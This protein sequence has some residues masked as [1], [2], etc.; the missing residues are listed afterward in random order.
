MNPREKHTLE[1]L[2]KRNGLILKASSK[3][4]NIVV[5]DQQYSTNMVHKLLDD[6][7]TYEILSRNP[8]DQI[9]RCNGGHIKQLNFGRLIQIHFQ[10]I[11]GFGNLPCNTKSAQT[12][13]VRLQ[14]SLAGS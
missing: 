12:N 1:Y 13:R 11:S 10:Y 3:G 7:E 8:T 6:R 9:K 5:M 14:Y 4:G 2:T